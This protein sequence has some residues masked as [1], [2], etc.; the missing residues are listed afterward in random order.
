M[1]FSTRLLLL[2]LRLQQKEGAIA[3]AAAAVSVM[4]SWGVCKMQIVPI[5]AGVLLAYI[6]SDAVPIQIH[7]LWKKMLHLMA[8]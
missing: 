6:F 3:A 8:A 7:N 1:I 4:F 5:A 2:L